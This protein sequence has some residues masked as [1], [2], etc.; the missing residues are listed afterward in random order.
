[1]NLI[2]GLK[3]GP[4]LEGWF[5]KPEG[6]FSSFMTTEIWQE[7]DVAMLFN[8]SSFSLYTLNTVISTPI[9]SLTL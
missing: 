7:D 2:S 4:K 1:M 6:A 3:I 9:M 8:A 5:L